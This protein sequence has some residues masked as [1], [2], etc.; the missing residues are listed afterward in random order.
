MK[1]GFTVVELV[2]VLIMIGIIAAI[3]VP[4]L[5]KA[6]MTAN[7]ASAISSL[8]LLSQAETERMILK[9][10]YETF[11]QLIEQG[12]I[13]E[14]FKLD[15]DGE[16]KATGYRFKLVM[17]GTS[18]PNFLILARPVSTNPVVMSGSRRFGVDRQQV[19]YADSTN[20]DDHFQSVE[21]L[22]TAHPVGD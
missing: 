12:I 2:I 3:A 18:P 16:A 13:D 17:L 22:Y 10:E 5:T 7:E 9:G 21:E 4:N 11:T 6:I 19:I 14:R 8:R 15:V 1:N 20:I